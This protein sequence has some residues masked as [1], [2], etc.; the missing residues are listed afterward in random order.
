MP[1]SVEDVVITGMSGRFPKSQSIEEFTKNL[2]NGVDMMTSGNDRCPAGVDGFPT[3]SGKVENLE[4]FDADFFDIPDK[5]AHWMDPQLRKLLEV[6]FEAIVDA[7]LDLGELNGSNTGL[8]YGSSFQDTGAAL[9]EN[10]Y[11]LPEYLQNYPTTV[12]KAFGLKGPIAQFDTACGSSFAALNEAFIA[13]KMG[14]CDRALV[15]G[16]NICLMPRVTLQFCEL[17]M[18]SSSG[19]S[20]SL[21]ESA[22]GYGRSEAVCCVVLQLKPEAKRIYSTIVNCRV[23]NDGYKEQGITFPSVALQRRLITETYDEVCLGPSMINYVEGHIT[24]TQAGDPAETQAIYD[25]FCQHRPVDNDPLMIGCLKSNMG[26][27]EAASGLCALVKANIIFQCGYI[28]PNINFKKPNPKIKGLMDGKIIPVLEKVPF[29]GSYIPLNSFGFGGFNAHLVL[30]GHK[31]KSNSNIKIHDEI[32]RLVAICSRTLE[33]VQRIQ[34]FLEVN[35]GS[36][37]AEFFDLLHSYSRTSSMPYKG[38]TI[39]D[40]NGMDSVFHHSILD[41]RPHCSH[42]LV[43]AFPA[44]PIKFDG[45]FRKVPFFSSTMNRLLKHTELLK[46]DLISLLLGESSP[47][48]T[49]E[50]NITVIAGQLLFVSFLKTLGITV[51]TPVGLLSEITR[52]FLKKS[53]SMEEAL[54]SA[55]SLENSVDSKRIESDGMIRTR[56]N[57]SEDGRIDTVK[58]CDKI[59]TVT[60]SHQKIRTEFN[61]S[62]PIHINGS[63]TE[64]KADD[65]ISSSLRKTSI[66]HQ[67]SSKFFDKSIE[68]SSIDSPV[69]CF[70]SSEIETFCPRK[71]LFMDSNCLRIKEFL[72]TIGTLYAMHC[73]IDIRPLYPPV[74]YPASINTLGLH[75]LIDFDHSRKFSVFK[76]PEYHN[77][78]SQKSSRLFEVSLSDSEDYFFADHVVDGQILFPAS[79]I[80]MQVWLTVT[81]FHRINPRKSKIMFCD[82]SLTRATMITDNKVKFRVDYMPH[83]NSFITTENGVPIANGKVF[84]VKNIDKARENYTI[85]ESKI[86]PNIARKRNPSE[87]SR[88]DIYKELRIRGYD[89]GRMFQCL[90]KADKN[91]KRAEIEWKDV[92]LTLS[93]DTVFEKLHG[94]ELSF[95]KSWIIYSDSIMQFSLFFNPCDRNLCIPTGFQS[96]LI[97]AEKITQ[98]IN[99]LNE[100]RLNLTNESIE[101]MDEEMKMKQNRIIF[102]VSFDSTTRTL[103]SEGLWVRGLK[104][105]LVSRRPQK[106]YIETHNFVPFMEKISID[107]EKREK[108]KDYQKTCEKNVSLE[109]PQKQS[110]DDLILQS[111]NLECFRTDLEYRKDS[112]SLLDCLINIFNGDLRKVETTEIDQDILVGRDLAFSHLKRFLQPFVSITVEDRMYHGQGNTSLVVMERNDGHSSH[113]EAIKHMVDLQTV[114]ACK[115][116]FTLAAFGLPSKAR[117]T[118]SAEYDH[119]EWDAESFLDKKIA[120]ND[121]LIYQNHSTNIASF[122]HKAEHLFDAIKPEGFLL[123]IF[124]EQIHKDT[125]KI[126]SAP[127]LKTVLEDIKAACMRGEDLVTLMESSGWICVSDRTLE[128][129]LISIRG[130][131]FRRKFDLIQEPNVFHVSPFDFQ[132]VEELKTVF[133]EKENTAPICLIGHPSYDQAV[134]GF[135]K[136]LG[137]ENSGERVFCIANRFHDEGIDLKAIDWQNPRFEN[138][139]EKRLKI[140][141]YDP[142][143]GWGGYVSFEVDE[144]HEE[145][146][147]CLVRTCDDVHLK[148]LQPGD[149]S[150]IKWCKSTDIKS[151]KSHHTICY[152]SLNFKDVL[153]ASGRLPVLIESQNSEEDFSTIKMGFEFSG[154]DENGHRIIG[155][156]ASGAMATHVKISPVGFVWPIPDEWTLEDAATVPVVYATAIYGLV[157]RGNLRRGESVLIHAGSGG[158]GMAAIYLCLS[159]DCTIFTTVGT[160]EKRKF[161]LEKFPQLEDANIGNSRDTSFEEMI[162]RRTDG[163]G[164]DI[165]L[166]SLAD[167]KLQASIRCL[168]PGGRFLEIG[169][170]DGYKNSPIDLGLLDGGRSFHDVILNSLSLPDEKVKTNSEMHQLQDLFSKFIENGTIKPLPRIVFPMNRVEDAFRFM[171]AGK[172]MGK[173]VVQVKGTEATLECNLVSALKISEFY[174]NKVYLIIGGFGGLGLEIALWLVSRGARNIVLNSR[175][176]PRSSYHHYSMEKMREKNAKVIISTHDLT[177]ENGCL[178]ISKVNI[179]ANMDKLSRKMCPLLDY[180]VVFSSASNGR[181]NTGQSNYSL[182]NSYIESLC[183]RRRRDGYHGL[184]IQ[185]G[186]VGDVGFVVEKMGIEVESIRGTAPQRLHSCFATLE[187]VLNYQNAVISSFVRNEGKKSEFSGDIIKSIGHILGMKDIYSCDRTI[188]LGELGMDSLMAIGVQQ[189]LDRNFGV[190]AT[191]REIRQMRIS[192]LIDLSNNS[193][194]I[195]PSKYEPYDSSLVEESNL[196]IQLTERI[197]KLNNQNGDI[198]FVFPPVEGD[199]SSYSGL[200]DNLQ[201]SAIGLRWTYDLAHLNSIEKVAEEFANRMTSLT[202]DTKLNMIGYSFG[203][204]LALA[205]ANVLERSKKGSKITPSRCEMIHLKAS[206]DAPFYHNFEKNKPFPA[207]LKGVNFECIQMPASTILI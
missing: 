143:H 205:I 186:Y 100:A 127:Q 157:M 156:L 170:Y 136:S 96:M 146:P 27:A 189:A 45:N 122:R 160:A 169:K 72:K 24:G 48:S 8:Y 6:S 134:V 105:S 179:T 145:D 195:S 97:D 141:I 200:F 70:E 66:A 88:E 14:L 172:H 149:L 162:L 63:S 47:K 153:L 120:R 71:V 124:R 125:D 130:L 30:R 57:S 91:V 135:T 18:V 82:V 29:R 144:K 61:N 3:H 83:D 184:A 164:V 174:P 118:L 131:L 21:D 86:D 60:D 147:Q 133:K 26:H 22:D 62:L 76:Y 173:V 123:I 53:I 201:H 15:A 204:L 25:V 151:S 132:W 196:S 113:F 64:T 58:S 187:R 188:T 73:Q 167:D 155:M 107:P 42:N 181:G 207:K 87:L 44:H 191:S 111:K 52:A 34:R 80:L 9:T 39:I 199:F 7:G 1:I 163:R 190:S 93:G 101:N 75:S 193:T 13:L 20:R 117:R 89:Y 126:L 85:L 55:Y 183:E 77:T 65:L 175:S 31:A 92:P 137:M 59:S 35:R 4:D 19:K 98:K 2:F 104:V 103:Q 37:T 154:Y 17:M 16:Y 138:I 168:A 177:T 81:K 171:A 74:D 161:I 129:D 38:Y 150:S 198:L 182:A 56:V 69:I 178:C 95:L 119:I 28:P 36:L 49:G 180:F 166:N 84:V 79:G 202:S 50:K 106:V 121:L 194:D 99:E 206:E 40:Q 90:V 128:P 115:L 203:G 165:V 109:H 197:I 158:V 152:A 139:L 114:G 10:P 78:Y 116:Y 32:P 23:N 12:S 54:N 67:I 33:G 140:N 148:V 94:A 43:V 102:D 46:I 192:D 51:I 176:G 142:V 41:I 110:R 108:L 11:S 185:W 5:H 68:L 112:S 159:Y